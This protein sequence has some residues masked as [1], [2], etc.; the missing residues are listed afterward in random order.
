MA[1]KACVECGEMVSEDAKLCP[2][3]GKKDPTETIADKIGQLVVGVIIFIG[4]MW[5]SPWSSS[6]D[7]LTK[8]GMKKPVKVEAKLLVA[9]MLGFEQKIPIV[10]IISVAKAITIKNV[11]LLL[12]Y[13]CKED[14]YTQVSIAIPFVN[15]VIKSGHS[16]TGVNGADRNLFYLIYFL[17]INL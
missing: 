16:I 11:Y 10:E 9:N 15:K 12:W 13:T 6:S 5:W 3:C 8:E 7:T 2:H 4:I 1:V 17:L 14:R